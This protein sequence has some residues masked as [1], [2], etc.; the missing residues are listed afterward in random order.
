MRLIEGFRISSGYNFLED[1]LRLQPFSIS[2]RSTLFEK[3]NIT[4][5]ANLDPYAVDSF[6]IRVN[7]FV[8]QGNRFSLPR[9][10]NASLSM[11]TSFKSKPRDAAKK[12]V[13]KNPGITD[14]A[15]LGE[16]QRMAEY[17]QRNPAEFVDFNVP[18][19]LD[20]SFSLIYTKQP[21]YGTG[22]F[23]TDVRSNVSFNNSF[24]LTPKWNFTTSGYYDFDTKQITNINMTIS[25]DMHCW[26]M[27]ATVVPIGISRS[28]SITISPKASVLQDLKVNRTRVF[29]D[30]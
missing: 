29:S 23:V 26:Q 9:T 6:G 5:Q 3:V 18:Y 25:R 8:W 27:S 12:P 17:I 2:F 20:L 11:S 16:R 4:G 14:P 10:T 28:F 15:L 30:Y 13:E 7:R 1:S 24:S 21:E 19:S 22:K